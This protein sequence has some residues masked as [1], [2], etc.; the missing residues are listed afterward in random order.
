MN[1]T[2]KSLLSLLGKFGGAFLSLISSVFLARYL[3]VEGIGQY[4]LILSTQV[5]LL[6]ILAMGYGNASIYFINSKQINKT[7]LVSTLLKVFL[8]L[9]L[10]VILFFTIGLSFFQNYFGILEFYGILFFSIGSG[11]LLL[12]SVLYPVLYVS[13]EVVKIQILSLLSTIIFL[14]GILFFYQTNYFDINVVIS[15]IGLGNLIPFLLLI[16]YLRHDINVKINIDYKILKKIF[17]YGVKLSATNLV[18]LL[19]SNLVIFL[20]KSLSDNG[21]ESIGLFSRA[22]AISNMFI[23]IPTSIGPLIYSKWASTEKEKLI[24]EV[25]KTIRLLVFISIFSIAGIIIFGDFILLTLYGREF[26]PAK[27]PLIVLSISFVFSSIT[28]V[29]INFFSSIGNPTITLKIFIWSLFTTGFT[30]FLLISYF[31]II[32]ASLAVLLGVIFNATMLF[33]FAKKQLNIKVSSSIIVKMSDFKFLLK[34]LKIK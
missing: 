11:S 12:Y 13:L 14:I 23:L 16:F 10:F 2:Q 9:S 34:A 6:T 22:T 24:K 28:I 3:G 7:T 32:G 25:E 4:Q 21:F 27:V 31:D 18:F 20:L 15:L 29:F 33:I 8:F 19:S 1:F 5:M 30:G 26:L 17:F